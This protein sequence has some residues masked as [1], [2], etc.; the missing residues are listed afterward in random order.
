MN[1]QNLPRTFARANGL[2][3]RI[4]EIVL[5]NEKGKSWTLDLKGKKSCGTVYIKRGW[6]SFC[7]ANGL[8][9][10]GFYTF[11]LNQR[12]GTPVLRLLSEE[13]EEEECSE[14]DERESLSTESESDEE[15]NQDEKNLKRRRSKWKASSSPSQNRFVTITLTPNNLKKSILVG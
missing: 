11:K 1:F 6:R 14:G 12:G 2:D 8:K 9:A 13:P 5:M 4:G 15:S 7:H 3:T 10:G